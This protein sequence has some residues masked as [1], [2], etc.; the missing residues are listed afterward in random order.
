[1]A[2]YNNIYLSGGGDEHQSFPLDKLFFD[3][4]PKN[5]R[6]LY[7]PVA[8]RGNKL[9]STASQWMSSILRLHNRTD[10]DL[11]TA[12]DINGYDIKKL[13]DF[14][15]VYIG[16]GNTWNLM[17]ELNDS[18]FSKLLLEY[19]EHDKKIYGGSAG[20][21]VLGELIDTHDD[22]NDIDY[23][24]NNG[25][26]V[27]NNHYSIAC[28]YKD[29]QID[30]YKQW[31]IKNDR[32]IICLYEETGLIINSNS[33]LCIGTKPCIIFSSDGTIIYHQSGEKF[34]L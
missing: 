25:L 20:A 2:Q 11:I 33:A 8:L 18:G 27:I 9:F 3:N 10:L 28:H 12:N 30:R 17:A 22:P 24:K 14:D 6:I 34:F 26:S 4:L 1:M 5:G 23:R 21:I 7:I 16:G 15:A 19:L 13:L 31:S 32:A 29:E